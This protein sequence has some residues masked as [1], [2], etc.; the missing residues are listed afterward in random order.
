MP[1]QPADVPDTPWRLTAAE[2]YV[3]R[4]APHRPAGT[5]VVKFAV[6]ELVVRG[7]LRVGWAS[8]TKRLSVPRRRACPVMVAGPRYD[9]VEDAVLEPVLET[10]ATARRRVIATPEGAHLE[11]VTLDDFVKAARKAFGGDMRRYANDHVVAML[12]R[13]GLVRVDHLMGVGPARLAYTP[14]GR[15]ADD[16]L[17]RWLAAGRKPFRTWRSPDATRVQRYLNGAGAA[18]VLLAH[19]EPELAPLNRVLHSVAPYGGEPLAIAIGPGDDLQPFDA[20]A[21]QLD[22]LAALDGLDGAFSAIDFG[23]V[24][25]G[26]GGGGD[27]GGGV[28]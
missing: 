5:E 16:E 26:G 11:A 19:L 15:E 14:A 25:A 18:V 20:S 2:S 17:E 3:L 22:D 27:G 6:K 28:G 12:E 21:L 13:R 8:A 4:H 1:E 24:D 10:Y 23:F 9:D 7:A